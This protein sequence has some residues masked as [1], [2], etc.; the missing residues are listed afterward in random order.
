MTIL[1]SDQTKSPVDP[2]YITISDSS[3]QPQEAA[4]LMTY[5]N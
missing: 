4:K 2:V 1:K 5:L 3:E